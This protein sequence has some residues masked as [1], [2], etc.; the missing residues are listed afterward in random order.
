MVIMLDSFQDNNCFV[1]TVQLSLTLGDWWSVEQ[2]DD[3]TGSIAVELKPMVYMLAQDNG[4]FV[5]GPSH[6]IG[7]GM[8]F[9]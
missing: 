1:T 3:I 4:L 8:H 6:D 7:M 2:F 9:W 5:T